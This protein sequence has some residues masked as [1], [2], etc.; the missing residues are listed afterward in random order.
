MTATELTTSGDINALAT[1]L[2]EIMRAPAIV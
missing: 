2:E 1:A